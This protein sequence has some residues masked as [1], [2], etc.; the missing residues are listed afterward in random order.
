[1]AHSGL[2]TGQTT[3]PAGGVFTFPD[4]VHDPAQPATPQ[5]YV[6]LAQPATPQH[7]VNRVGWGVFFSNSNKVRKEEEEEEEEEKFTERRSR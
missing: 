6:K 7:Y 1:M 3:P 2:H 4:T 5:H